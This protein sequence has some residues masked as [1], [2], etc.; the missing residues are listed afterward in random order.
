MQQTGFDHHLCENKATAIFKK[1]KR[2]AAI[3]TCRP[4]SQYAKEVP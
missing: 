1:E 4:N 3:K 2:N